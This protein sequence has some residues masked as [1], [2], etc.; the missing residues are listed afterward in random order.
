MF[1]RKGSDYYLNPNPTGAILRVRRSRIVIAVSIHTPWG[2]QANSR[3]E[4]ILRVSIDPSRG[5]NASGID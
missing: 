3:F 4:N 5:A 1:C 2:D